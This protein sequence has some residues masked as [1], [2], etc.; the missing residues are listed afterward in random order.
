MSDHKSESMSELPA[1]QRI[2]MVICYTSTSSRTQGTMISAREE[3][4]S[5][6]GTLYK[7]PPGSSCYLIV[8]AVVLMVTN[9]SVMVTE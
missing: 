9:I 2:C 7:T 5:I 4:W 1:Q 3:P 6:C 8:T